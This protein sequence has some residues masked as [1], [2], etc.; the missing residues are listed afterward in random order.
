MAGFRSL[1]RHGPRR[2]ARTVQGAAAASV[3]FVGLL[4]TPLTAQAIDIQRVVSPRGIE[5]WLVEDHRVPVISLQM[6]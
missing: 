2:A 4:L 6:P 5:A 3:M 1:L